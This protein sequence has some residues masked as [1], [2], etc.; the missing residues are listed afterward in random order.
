[1]ESL[2]LSL[3]EASESESR[4]PPVHGWLV[5]TM[6]DVVDLMQ[7]AHGPVATPASPEN[8][9][10]TYRAYAML[11]SCCALCVSMHVFMYS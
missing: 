4:A 5:R 3:L 2:S 6:G 8:Q 10:S 9:L 7:C 11:H 1:M